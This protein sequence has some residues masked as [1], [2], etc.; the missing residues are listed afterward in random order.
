[1]S[2][3]IED[4]YDKR[5]KRD[6]L[7]NNRNLLQ[8]CTTPAKV[9]LRMKGECRRTVDT[10]RVNNIVTLKNLIPSDRWCASPFK[11]ATY[12]ATIEEC[13]ILAYSWAS[14]VTRHHMELKGVLLDTAHFAIS[15]CKSPKVIKDYLLFI[16]VDLV[17]MLRGNHAKD[18]MYDTFVRL[19]GLSDKKTYFTKSAIKSQ[20]VIFTLDVINFH[21][22]LIH[23]YC[24]KFNHSELKAILR[25]VLACLGVMASE[26]VIA[27]FSSLLW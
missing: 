2:R 13:L 1:M 21:I 10:S 15:Y 11:T 20:R 23:S 26:D 5:H 19:L 4:C 7:K 25:S 3:A 6:R 14:E 22:D 16:L 12:I 18:P 8:F 17:F 9:L 24:Q 27:H